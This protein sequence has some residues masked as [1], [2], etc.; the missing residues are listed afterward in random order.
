M[1]LAYALENA[2]LFYSLAK[3]L[4]AKV[5]VYIFETASHRE[6]STN[7]SSRKHVS[8]VLDFYPWHRSH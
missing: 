2:I 1:L 7:K 3:K 5:S 8:G 6:V 4:V